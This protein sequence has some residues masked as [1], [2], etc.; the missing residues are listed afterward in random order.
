MAT[1]MWK[2]SHQRR[3]TPSTYCIGSIT[4]S[5]ISAA[6]AKL[7]DEKRVAWDTPI[8][9]IL[10]E[11]QH[12]NPIITQMTTITDILSHR[13]GLAGFGAMNLAFQGDGTMLL[14]KDSLFNIVNHILVLFPFRQSWRY[15][16]WCYSL[17]G[18]II[19]RVTQKSLKEF[20]SKI[21]FQPLGMKNTSFSPKD[22]KLGKLAELYAGLSDGSVF[23]LP[24]LQVFKD[25]FFEASGGMFSSLDDLMI[26]AGVMLK[27]INST[28]IEDPFIKEAPYI[29]SNH[30]AMFN[31]SISERSYGLG[32]VRTQLLGVV[33]LI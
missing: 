25:T 30:A 18:A 16:V 1:A 8:K 9:D 3:L 22:A 2:P 28:D 27:S 12:D 4:K 23:C 6:I 26:W 13:S 32:W 19:E 29:F 33:G 31:L 5:F 24:K 15:F 7:V 10:P 11:F 21:L 20:L 17:A 14:P